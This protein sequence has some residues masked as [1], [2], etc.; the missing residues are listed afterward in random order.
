MEENKQIFIYNRSSRRRVQ[1]NGTSEYGTMSLHRRIFF[2]FLSRTADYTAKMSDA[3]YLVFSFFIINNDPR[4][5]SSNIFTG[6]R[7]K[8]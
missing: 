3:F 1:C 2:F 4:R 7:Y 5:L 8:R 6:S